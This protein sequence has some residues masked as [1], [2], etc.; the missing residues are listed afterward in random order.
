MDKLKELEL[1]DISRTEE[2]YDSRMSDRE[3]KMDDMSNLDQPHFNAGFENLEKLF[4]DNPGL[5]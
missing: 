4:G 1:S 3:S 5:L 2:L